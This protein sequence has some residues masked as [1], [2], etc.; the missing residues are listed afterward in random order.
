M[1]RPLGTPRGS[2]CNAGSR[3][4]L[5]ARRSRRCKFG[6]WATWLICMSVVQTAGAI[7]QYDLSKWLATDRRSG[8]AALDRSA[9]ARLHCWC[10]LLLVML[11]SGGVNTAYGKL[12]GNG[13]TPRSALHP[14]RRSGLG[15]RVRS[16]RRKKLGQQGRRWWT[17]NT[18][19]VAMMLALFVWCIKCATPAGI[20]IWACRSGGNGGSGGIDPRPMTTLQRNETDHVVDD[21]S[22][23]AL[24]SCAAQ[25]YWLREVTPCVGY[26]VQMRRCW[27]ARPPSAESPIWG[28]LTY[29][30]REATW[31]GGC[32]R[33]NRCFWMGD[34][35]REDGTTRDV[36]VNVSEWVYRVER[37]GTYCNP[38]WPV[39]ALQSN[40]PADLVFDLS[41]STPS[42]CA[43][44]LGWLREVTSCVGCGVQK[45]RRRE[46]GPPRAEPPNR[47]MLTDFHGDVD[48]GNGCHWRNRYHR[49]ARFA[50]DVRSRGGGS[51][52][53]VLGSVGIC[54]PWGRL[55]QFPGFANG[56]LTAYAARAGAAVMS[57][58]ACREGGPLR[59]KGTWDSLQGK[60]PQPLVVLDG[61]FG[62]VSGV[63]RPR[64][65]RCTNTAMCHGWPFSDRADAVYLP[66]PAFDWVIKCAAAAILHVQSACDLCEDPAVAAAPRSTAVLLVSARFVGKSRR[67]LARMRTCSFYGVVGVADTLA[68][69]KSG[70]PSGEGSEISR[71]DA[72]HNAAQ[73]HHACILL[74]HVSVLDRRDG[75]GFV[76]LDGRP[77]GGGQYMTAG[78]DTAVFDPSDSCSGSGHPRGHRGPPD[79]RNGAAGRASSLAKSPSAQLCANLDAARTTCSSAGPSGSRG[80][81][82]SGSRGDNV[83]LGCGLANP[84][85]P[86]A[87]D[88]D[89]NDPNRD[90]RDRVGN[91]RRDRGRK[92]GRGP[93]PPPPPRPLPFPVVIAGTAVVRPPMK[94]RWTS[95]ATPLKRRA[96]G[97]AAGK[98]V[99][100]VPHSPRRRRTRACTK[101]GIWAAPFPTTIPNRLTAT[102][103]SAVTGLMLMVM[104]ARSVVGLV[105]LMLMSPMVLVKGPM[106][107]GIAMAMPMTMRRSAATRAVSGIVVP[108]VVPPPPNLT[109]LLGRG[110]REV[111][112]T[113]GRGHNAYRV[114]T[115]V[116]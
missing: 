76:G 90:D 1:P 97:R 20:S 26:G 11:I 13:S 75:I 59:G 91:T 57:M 79:P 110:G 74:V 108:P 31:C 23:A 6:G 104:L 66:L 41:R 95:T 56:A 65:R 35:A 36:G 99:P 87:Q 68:G 25:L 115:S 112:R 8:D 32:D 47:G 111:V 78:A 67:P 116:R 12:R 103:P 16:R 69:I 93:G 33:G 62:D 107:D 98:M 77:R 109:G 17:A 82:T 72:A 43:V 113:R 105:L 9:E 45:R 58:W 51:A 106:R 102:S 55:D 15:G 3:S 21:S 60:S 80:Y 92:E 94:W 38:Q 70:W 34:D 84:L 50:R 89:N 29:S 86:E 40:C 19:A 28:M 114:P 10:T 100:G 52:S 81:F 4:I 42:S 44:Q 46:D 63:L 83:V 37:C 88:E 64:L 53:S 24:A 39:H 71:W 54:R 5:A 73:Q 14:S 22:R 101:R 7:E 30:R 18:V 85:R 61:G 96:G 27:V 48:L 2:E 49:V